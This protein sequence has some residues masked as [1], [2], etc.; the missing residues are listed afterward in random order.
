MKKTVLALLVATISTLATAAN[1][2]GDGCSGTGEVAKTE[3]GVLATCI[4][5][6]LLPVQGQ[7]QV[8]VPKPDFV[9]A[10]V[11]DDGQFTYIDFGAKL[12]A[13]MPVLFERGEDGSSVLRNFV[14]DG[15]RIKVQGT[16]KH[17]TLVLGKESVEI[18]RL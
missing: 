16:L 13:R 7:Y 12:P 1:Q 9:P 6:K 2:I 10:V 11:W 5:G 3:Q 15:T 8:G 17:G 18:N 4:G 14:V